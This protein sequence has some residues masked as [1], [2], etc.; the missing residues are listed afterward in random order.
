MSHVLP[1]SYLDLAGGGG[2]GEVG[3]RG[4]LGLARAGRDHGR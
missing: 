1:P 4:V 2:D 3:D